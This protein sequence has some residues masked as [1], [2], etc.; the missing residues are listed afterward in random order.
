MLMQMASLAESG[1]VIV[2]AEY[3]VPVDEVPDE[4][5]FPTPAVVQMLVDNLRARGR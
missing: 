2:E 5:L 4:P 3:E 1:L